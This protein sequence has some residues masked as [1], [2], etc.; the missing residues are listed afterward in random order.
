MDLNLTPE[1]RAFRDEA[2]RY[3]GNYDV[4][5]TQ[6]VV[7]SLLG[8]G[9]IAGFWRVH[10]DAIKSVLAGERTRAV[11]SYNF[12]ATYEERLPLVILALDGLLSSDPAVSGESLDS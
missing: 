1:L 2:M 4:P 7:T 6:T 3:D 5:A 11:V 8:R 10:G 12:R 9:E